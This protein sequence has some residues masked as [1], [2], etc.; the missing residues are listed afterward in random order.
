MNEI[1]QHP[2]K[3]APAFLKAP[4]C[5]ARNRQGKPCQRPALRKKDRCAL[6]GGRSTGPKTTAG[7]QA[8]RKAQWKDGSRSERLQ[9]EFRKWSAP[10]ETALQREILEPILEARKNDSPF[11]YLELGCAP[12]PQIQ[13]R[14]HGK[15]TC[16]GGPP[17]EWN[18][19]QSKSADTSGHGTGGVP[20]PNARA[21]RR[22]LL[23]AQEL[24]EYLGEALRADLADIQNDDGTFKPLSV[25]PEV[26]RRLCDGGDVE[27]EFAS[28]RS[29]DGAT[30]DKQGGWDIKGEVRRVRFKFTPRAKLL[31]LAMKHKAVDAMVQQKNGPDINLTVVTAEKARQV[32]A[33]RRRLARVIPTQASAASEPPE[34]QPCPENPPYRTE[35]LDGKQ[36]D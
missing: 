12:I 9:A 5:G 33:A 23:D 13:V 8:I 24:H 16:L 32:S 17:M 15:A 35:I 7:I 31:E 26:W 4:R 34:S 28:Q 27:V 25:W 11:L 21:P 6:H 3:R 22:G 20:A 29:H 1:A 19:D 14:Y 36:T 30:K 2:M 18:S 10:Q